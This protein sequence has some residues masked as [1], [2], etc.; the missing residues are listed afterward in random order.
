MAGVITVPVPAT[1]TDPAL[2]LRRWQPRDIPALVEAHTDPAMRRWLMR[3]IDDE[4]MAREALAEQVREWEAG[5]RFNFAVVE[6]GDAAAALELDPIAGVVVKRMHPSVD[7]A[8]VG[9]WVSATARG[10]R[11]APRAVAAA[12]EWAYRVWADNP[13]A[14]VNLIHTVGNDA[15]CRV[16]E[17][18]G[19]RLE[20]RYPPHP[21]KFPEPAHL[22]VLRP[23]SP[24]SAER[25]RPGT[26][27][28]R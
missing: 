21:V 11:I 24:G 28:T 16:A 9:Y 18:L 1:D 3:H 6:T 15:S 17:K 4:V 27:C 12:L 14:R 22:H 8:E 7:E 20:E 26:R 23:G 10:R 13:V 25:D 5:A 2:T 19:F